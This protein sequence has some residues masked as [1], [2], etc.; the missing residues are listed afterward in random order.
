MASISGL[1]E[2]V[3]KKLEAFEQLKDE[4]ERSFYYVQEMHGQKRFKGVLLS[5]IIRYLHALWVCECKDRLL[6]IPKSIKRY[7]GLLC[8]ELLRDW[9]E[10]ESGIAPVVAFLQRK[11]DMMSFADLTRQIYIARQE[12]RDAGLER[13]LIHGRAVLLNRGMNLM[14][15]LETLFTLAEDSSLEEVRAICQ[16]MGH[17]P[18]QISQ[19][20]ALMKT[21]LYAYIPHQA[22][23]Q[24]NMRL[25]NRLGIEVLTESADRS[26]QGPGIVV[27]SKISKAPYAVT[28]IPGYQ[29]LPS[30]TGRHSV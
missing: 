23:A 20:I 3:A 30:G 22:L 11:L 13:R 14:A 16:Q 24:T 4:F 2:L 17:T 8:L 26:G 12:S 9:Q 1:P 27:K 28:V 5:D 25:M 7:E 15:A 6:G 21:P 10:D 29:E 18:E 19:Q